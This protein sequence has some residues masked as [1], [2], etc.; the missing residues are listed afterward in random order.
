[1]TGDLP[2][3]NIWNQTKEDQL[4]AINVLTDLFLK[5][6]PNKRIYSTLGNHEAAPSNL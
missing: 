3:H 6:F 2:P 4:N 5:Y 1:M